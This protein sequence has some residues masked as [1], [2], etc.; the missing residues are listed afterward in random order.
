M[1]SVISAVPDCPEEPTLITT[2]GLDWLWKL[3]PPPRMTGQTSPTRREP[4]GIVSVF[5]T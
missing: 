2:C 5:V 1:M 4:G 3:E